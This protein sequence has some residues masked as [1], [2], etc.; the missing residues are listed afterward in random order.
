MQKSNETNEQEV[1]IIFVVAEVPE[2]KKP[3]RRFVCCLEGRPF[4]KMSIGN[5]LTLPFIYINKTTDECSAG[6]RCLNLSCYYNKTTFD[7][8]ADFHN[9]PVA[10]RP[11]LLKKWPKLTQNGQDL[12]QAA[13]KCKEAHAKNPNIRVFCVR[14]GVLLETKTSV[15]KATNQKK[16]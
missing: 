3:E 8:Y 13:E 5:L 14:N 9:E 12:I 10:C 2:K 6:H 15:K 11:K 7:S 1:P 4:E 16:A